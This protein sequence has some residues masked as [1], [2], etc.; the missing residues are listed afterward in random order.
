M[1]VA[2]LD[3]NK[4]SQRP[5][6]VCIHCAAIGK[7]LERHCS[8]HAS[9]GHPM[10]L[11]VHR[12]ELYCCACRDYIYD[13]D[14]YRCLS[15]AA[16]SALSVDNGSTA[17]VGGKPP[18]AAVANGHKRKRAEEPASDLQ[19]LGARSIQ[20][21]HALPF[22]LRG[23]SN[24]GNT[25]F[26]NSVL[27]ALLHAP[28]LRN[29][30][31]GGSHT[32]ALCI[33][34]QSKP[35]LSCEL[36]GLFSAAYSGASAPFSPAAFLYAWWCHADH[37]LAGYQQQD[38]HEFYLFAL[39]GLSHS[40]L[41]GEAAIKNGAAAADT[42]GHRPVTVEAPR[43]AGSAGWQVPVLAHTD[44]L[45]L[46]S[47]VDSPRL[48]AFLPP[49]LDED[50]KTG[51]DD[52]AASN[53][54]ASSS[55]GSGAE[56]GNSALQRIFGGLLQSDVMCCACGHTSTAHDPFLD[57]SLDIK[58]PPLPPA[59]L[60][61]PPGPAHK[62]TATQRRLSGAAAMAVAAAQKRAASALGTDPSAGTSGETAAPA[63]ASPAAAAAAAA[64][65]LP[66]E[67]ASPDTT[68][69]SVVGEAASVAP[70][71]GN[72]AADRDDSSE[73]LD[74]I[75]SYT[76]E[77]SPQGTTSPILEAGG[78]GGTTRRGSTEGDGGEGYH[79]SA[80]DASAP[81]ASTTRGAPSSEGAS[82]GIM[83]DSQAGLHDEIHTSPAPGV[84]DAIDG[85]QFW[86]HASAPLPATTPRPS[87]APVQAPARPRSGSAGKKQ[88]PTRCMKC[89]TCLKPQL[90]KACLRNK[91]L[92][93]AG[94]LAALDESMPPGDDLALAAP[95]SLNRLPS[96][97]EEAQAAVSRSGSFSFP[98]RGSLPLPGML[99]SAAPA[100]AAAAA[101]VAAVTSHHRLVSAAAARSPE[102]SAAPS[103]AP[104]AAA[105]AALAAT[106]EGT[107]A[108]AG[109]YQGAPGGTGPGPGSVTAQYGAASLQRAVKQM[110]IRRLPPVLCLHVKRFEHTGVGKKLNTPLIFAAHLDVRPYLSSTVLQKRFTAKWPS[111]Q[112][113]NGRSG[114]EAD[115]GSVIYE[116]YAVVCHRGNLQGGHYVAYVKCN[117]SWSAM[118][119]VSKT[120]LRRFVAHEDEL[121]IK[122]IKFRIASGL[123]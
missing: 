105:G 48:A 49:K 6:I 40:R 11:D 118:M 38:A 106:T 45:G 72:A 39:S 71:A 95:A 116:L 111:E 7:D 81:P 44:I 82:S 90:K 18:P 30:Y 20:R 104:S 51:A 24:L 107:P 94:N 12:S 14:F 102:P 37:H 75:G 97:E 22:G 113:R 84:V 61:R 15:G 74:I 86:R 17:S 31:L 70:G 28:L 34:R 46:T 5:A 47:D 58:P 56:E 16:A 36:D 9:S 115:D 100:A 85:G 26:M 93:S 101:P 103:V 57:I 55:G 114:G 88:R 73:S 119:L 42:A 41:P 2:N 25:C 120:D 52:R 8:Q 83:G 27:Q 89:A 66:D 65:Q 87:S 91:A 10:A 76:R 35:C 99:R 67:R 78:S 80:R 43:P 109:T 117:S 54:R 69:T 98:T 63:A 122:T 92:R 53:E 64:T 19:R 23:L 123:I 50:A 1:W 110:S 4:A 62:Q 33:H 3:P 59:P 96:G 13:P 32:A 68:A 79:S 112:P 108:T 29:F 60:L 21:A 77:P 121:I